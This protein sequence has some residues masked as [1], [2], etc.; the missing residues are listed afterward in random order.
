MKCPKCG[1][2]GFETTDRCRNCG[3][4]FSLAAPV[5]SAE[6]PLREG[7][8]EAVMSDLALR[9]AP[10]AAE[11]P[12]SLH[13]REAAGFGGRPERR[14]VTPVPPP[15]AAAASI[16]AAPENGPESAAPARQDEGAE[17]LPLFAP[18]P[19]GTPLAV[20]R[21]GAEVPKAR[22]TTTRP[23]RQNEPVLPLGGTVAAVVDEWQKVARARTPQVAG[24]GGRLLAAVI[25]LVLLL[26]IHAGVIWLTLRL[27]GLSPTLQD[28]RVI[29]PIPMV[30]FLMVLTFLYLTGFT[31]GGGQSIG[32]MLV[33]IRVTGDD[34]HGVDITG[35][36][37]R[38][39]GCM[40][41]M[42]TL[43]LFFV[44]AFFGP[45]RRAVHDRMA[46]TRVVVA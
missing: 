7:S 25:D 16:E 23:L 46:G 9:D 22:R 31:V 3:Y 10:A 42:A 38:A 26:A 2:L 36:V 27:A 34:G 11:P 18:R 35:A 12:L 19:A 6:L 24:L 15:T 44:P 8:S 21:Q 13:E 33:G 45:E 1:Y 40:G 28:V 17:D 14:R 4:D 20:R 30:A 37:V 29:P 5:P 43:G 32:K 41:A 39:L